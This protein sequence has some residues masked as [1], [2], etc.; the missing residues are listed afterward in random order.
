MC[1]CVFLG[2]YELCAFIKVI[3]EEDSIWKIVVIITTFLCCYCCAA[4]VVVVLV[5]YHSCSLLGV[6]I[7][8]NL[9]F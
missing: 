7:H 9:L 8:L 2:V 6:M 4:A 3:E 5:A 1:V